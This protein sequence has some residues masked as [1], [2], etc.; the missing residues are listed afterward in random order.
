MV[1]RIELLHVMICDHRVRAS[2]D[3][4]NVLRGGH[5]TRQCPVVITICELY[6]LARSLKRTNIRKEKHLDS[7]MELVA[8]RAE[9]FAV[10]LVRRH[11]S[12]G[13]IGR[14]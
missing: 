2:F 13:R 9:E 5:I 11:Q 4:W 8:R 14:L 10:V 12:L 1:V 3:G 7:M 6:E